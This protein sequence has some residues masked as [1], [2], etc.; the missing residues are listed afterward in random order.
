MKYRFTVPPTTEVGSYS[1]TCAS[2]I[3]ETYRKNAL[4]DYNS[5]RAHDGLPP[6]DRMPAGTVYTA[7]PEPRKWLTEYI[8]QGYYQGHGWEDETAEDNRKDARQRLK[9]YRENQPQYPHRMIA[10]RVRNE[11]ATA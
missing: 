9:E 8:V 2:S 4:S 6:L 11:V 3:R 10:R 1:G 7:I 5:C